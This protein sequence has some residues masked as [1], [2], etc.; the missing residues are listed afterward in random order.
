MKILF[1]YTELADYTLACLRTLKQMRSNTE[2]L[3]IHYPVNPEAPFRFSFDDIGKFICVSSYLSYASLKENVK[4]FSPDKI[5]SSG[6]VNKWYLR[7]CWEF[8]KDSICILAL[9]NHWFN[10][11]KQRFLQAISRFT[12]VRIFRKVWVP[13]EPQVEYAVRL[14]FNTEGIMKGFYSCDINRFNSWYEMS[15]EAKREDF[16]TRLLCVARYIPAKGLHALWDAFVE[17]KNIS[18]NNW[19][20]WCAGTGEQ[21]DSRVQH[22]AI[23]H[24]GFVQ[25]EDWEDII[26]QTGIFVLPSV[27][28]PWGVVVHEFAA[29]GY[30]LLLSKYV[31]AGSLFLSQKNGFDF[32]PENKGEL[33]ACLQKISELGT[34]KLSEMGKV[35]HQKAQQITPVAW[36]HTLID[37]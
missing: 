6:W 13:G 20:L 37:F 24:L 34:E 10:T 21:F 9:D 26:R 22:P 2:V 30:P 35:S 16:P 27:F 36:T 33:I 28:E 1:L 25:K 8:R 17:W 5:V 32:N 23:K 31:G 15:R 7:I 19:E 4:K 18:S 14:G 3:V 11:P 12:L 29:S